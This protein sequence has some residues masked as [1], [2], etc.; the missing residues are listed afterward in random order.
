MDAAYALTSDLRPR[1]APHAKVRSQTEP[2]SAEYTPGT[3]PITHEHEQ[4]GSDTIYNLHTLFF[5]GPPFKDLF[6]GIR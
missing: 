6:L 5:L 4:M 1:R 2:R 3:L